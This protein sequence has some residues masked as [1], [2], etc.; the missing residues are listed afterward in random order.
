M[1]EEIEKGQERHWTVQERENGLARAGRGPFQRDGSSYEE[2]VAR[3]LSEPERNHLPQTFAEEVARVARNTEATQ[4]L[5]R[6]RESLHL[7]ALWSAVLI[8]TVAFLVSRF[9]EGA[10]DSFR[11]PLSGPTSIKWTAVLVA[12]VTASSCMRFV[13]SSFTRD[14]NG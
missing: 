3:V 14:F 7:L 2:L 6:K 10:L 8:A 11:G 12:C 13:M 1:S 9:S 5:E 4:M